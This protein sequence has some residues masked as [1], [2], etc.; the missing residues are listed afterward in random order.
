MGKR[1]TTAMEVMMRWGPGRSHDVYP[2][3]TQGLPSPLISFL[4]MY[5]IRYCYIIEGVREAI[6]MM[7]IYGA[8]ALAWMK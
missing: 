2:Y 8:I 5:N 3:V 1:M 4:S 7:A 6:T